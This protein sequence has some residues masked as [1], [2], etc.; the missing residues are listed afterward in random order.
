MK[1]GDLLQLRGTG[2]EKK[3][4]TRVVLCDSPSGTLM[5][6]V[7]FPP[8]T[9]ALFVDFSRWGEAGNRLFVVVGGRTGLVW[10]DE[11]APL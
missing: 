9:A 11:V 2:R 8:G 6:S 5:D 3:G 7:F 1:P 4:P 10:S